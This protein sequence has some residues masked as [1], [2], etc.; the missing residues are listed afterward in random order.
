[1]KLMLCKKETNTT[2]AEGLFGKS[3][4]RKRE[5]AGNKDTQPHRREAFKVF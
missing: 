1:M 2:E 4:Q 5:M 3:A